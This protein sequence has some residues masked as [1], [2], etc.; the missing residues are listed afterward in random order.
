MRDN[1]IGDDAAMAFAAALRVN[2]TLKK[3]YIK[4]NNI[5]D[6]GA[7]AL[8]DAIKKN[9]ALKQ[10]DL[11]VNCMTKPGVDALLDAKEATNKEITCGYQKSGFRATGYKKEG[12]GG[13]LRGGRRLREQGHD[14][15]VPLTDLGFRR[16][17][18]ASEVSRWAVSWILLVQTAGP[19]QGAEDL[20]PTCVRKTLLAQT[21]SACASARASERGH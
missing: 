19:V 18:A 13:H 11:E 10:L 12:E 6:D 14:I 9:E 16:F 7:K 3:L 20:F 21:S 15:C 8:A 1:Q 5:G 17:Q 4:D 2:G